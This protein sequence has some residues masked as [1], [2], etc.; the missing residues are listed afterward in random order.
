MGEIMA[1]LEEIDAGQSETVI[2]RMPTGVLG[3]DEVLQ[4]GLV[5]QRAYLLHG[6]PG[7]GKTMLGLHFLTAGALRGERALFITMGETE[8]QIR[9]NA[10]SVG[11]DLTGVKFL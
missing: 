3:L 11:F 1:Q 10:A 2:Q 6:N 5:A 7:S 8:A 4:G 9:V